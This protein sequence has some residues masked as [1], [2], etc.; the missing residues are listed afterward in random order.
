MD[1]NGDG[2][3]D[4]A[5][6][7][8]A[9]YYPGDDAGERFGLSAYHDDA[10]GADAVNALPRQG[11]LAG[12]LTGQLKRT[13]Q[14]GGGTYGNFYA[15]CLQA[16]KPRILQTAAFYSPETGGSG[17][18]EIKLSWW[19]QVLAET[20]SEAFSATAAVVWD[21]R[22]STRDT[23]EGTIVWW[24][25]G[26]PGIA[27]AAAESLK[28]ALVTGPVTARGYPVENVSGGGLD[29]G[30]RVIGGAGAWVVAAL[31]ALAVCLLWLL[32]RRLHRV[33]GWAYRD[34]SARD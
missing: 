2:H 20:S 17:E 11:E 23:V 4:S 21:E 1:T 28:S 30:G 34:P 29:D 16:R 5:D 24:I 10:S 9:P 8:Y 7:A 13:G 32:L 6:D 18:A 3:W 33:A 14:D 15:D 27:V 12:M 19:N 22:T 26:Q 31:T 25:T